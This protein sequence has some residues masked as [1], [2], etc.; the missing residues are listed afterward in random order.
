MRIPIEE[1]DARSKAFVKL[2][3]PGEEARRSKAS[4]ADTPEGLQN[5][6]IGV[7]RVSLFCRDNAVVLDL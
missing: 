7:S 2:L 4:I 3:L 5:V 1:R 6:L